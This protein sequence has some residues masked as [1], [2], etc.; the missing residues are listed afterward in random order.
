MLSSTRQ[1]IFL[2]RLQFQT[3]H[4]VASQTLETL[5]S[6]LDF[7]VLNVCGQGFSDK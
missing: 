6:L 4:V 7:T 1:L 3:I 2:P 5:I